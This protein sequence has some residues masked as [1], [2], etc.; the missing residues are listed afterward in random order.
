MESSFTKSLLPT[1]FGG[2]LS[3]LSLALVGYQLSIYLYNYFAHPLRKI[4]GP[5]LASI[6]TFPFIIKSFQGRKVHWLVELHAKYGDAVRIAPGDVSFNGSTAF[7]DMAG[8]KKP[9][10]PE[11]PKSPRMYDDPYTESSHIIAANQ[12][13]HGRLRKIFSYA[14]SDRALR[15]QEKLLLQ[16]ADRLVEVMRDA[17]Q[18]SQP[19][20]MVNF[21]NR[22]TFDIMSDLVFGEAFD[23]L[24]ST[25][26]HSWMH[27][28]INTVAFGTYVICIRLF[29]TLSNLLF[30]A[31]PDSVLEKKRHHDA[32]MRS[33][34]KKRMEFTEARPDI[35]GLI[36]ERVGKDESKGKAEH[37]SEA[38]M[39]ANASILMIAGTETTATLLSGLTFYLLKNPPKLQR[40][41]DEIEAT[42]QSGDDIN[43][44]RLLS[45]K[46]L[47]ACLEEGLRIYPP[48][49]DALLRESPAGAPSFVGG[50]EIAPHVSILTRPL[51]SNNSTNCHPRPSCMFQTT[52]A[53][54]TRTT[55]G[56]PIRSF[57][58]GGSTARRARHMPVT[59]KTPSSPFPPARETALARISPTT[60]CG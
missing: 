3:I 46:Y 32:L 27:A 10:Q 45:M 14:F 60:R 29:P 50:V 26:L 48:V 28:I 1:T 52:R 39:R 31:L 9:G 56:T 57:P 41:I 23:L 6:S 59:S 19:L 21:Y 35:L 47:H 43:V 20:N 13:E 2:I 22:T 53:L 44:D 36:L 42:F 58:R 37:L 55:S 54:A 49:A 17:S 16:Y 33:S 34:V 5:F 18:S 40:L 4:P 15:M 24:R 38:E 12:A 25:K 51:C 7:K 30:W 8:F 11:F